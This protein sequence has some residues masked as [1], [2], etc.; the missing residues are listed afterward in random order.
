M[1]ATITKHEAIAYELRARIHPS[2][3][4]L[5]A[6]IDFDHFTSEQAKLI[7]ADDCESVVRDLV[8]ELRVKRL[9]P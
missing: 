5:L 6:E 8:R 9:L 7:F 2:L 4:P 1:P 3:Q